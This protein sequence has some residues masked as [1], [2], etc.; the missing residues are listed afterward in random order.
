MTKV[1]RVQEGRLEEVIDLRHV[2]MPSKV[3]GPE[4]TRE[5]RSLTQTIMS[6]SKPWEYLSKIVVSMLDSIICLILCS[7]GIIYLIPMYTDA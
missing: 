2:T 4:D 6:R 5:S 3:T 7:L 1:V